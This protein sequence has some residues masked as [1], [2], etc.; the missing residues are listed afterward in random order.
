MMESIPGDLPDIKYSYSI[1][2]SD[3]VIVYK[4]TGTVVMLLKGSS[5]QIKDFC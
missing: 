4:A 5:A 3:S 1:G 2:T